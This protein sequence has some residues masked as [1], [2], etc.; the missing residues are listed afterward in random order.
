[1]TVRIALAA[2]L[3]AASA[4]LAAQ[5]AA[6]VPPVPPARD[7]VEDAPAA[8]DRYCLRET[9]SRIHARRASSAQRCRSLGFGR[10]YTQDDLQRTGHIDIAQALRALDPSIY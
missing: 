9:G 7:A 1:M 10:A 3:L 2:L 6:S 4:P 8:R 5:S